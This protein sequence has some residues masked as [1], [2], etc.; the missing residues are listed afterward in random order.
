[1][2]KTASNSKRSHKRYDRRHDGVTTIQ[3]TPERQEIEEIRL[4]AQW[5]EFW[6]RAIE[7]NSQEQVQEKGD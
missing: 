5:D 6:N 2:H 3:A 4:R 1:M 7:R